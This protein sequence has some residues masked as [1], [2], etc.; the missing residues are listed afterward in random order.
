MNITTESTGRDDADRARR[1]GSVLWAKTKPLLDELVQLRA[2]VERL[3]PDDAHARRCRTEQLEALCDIAIGHI[4]AK[5]EETRYA[6]FRPAKVEAHL[7]QSV[8][9]ECLGEAG[10]RK[11]PS[12]GIVQRCLN[13]VGLWP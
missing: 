9:F 6:R 2:E 13:K 3:R 11:I 5:L 1:E 12:R 7:R 8:E 4:R 10:R